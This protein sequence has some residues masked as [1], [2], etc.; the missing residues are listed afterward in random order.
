MKGEQIDYAERKAMERF[1][2]WND[3]SGVIEPC[4]GY[5]SEI[6]GV[7]EDAVHI[8]AQMALKGKILYNED[9]EIKRADF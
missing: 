9:G 5:Y 7:I 3:V 2:E 1:D 4:G 8:G 6:R